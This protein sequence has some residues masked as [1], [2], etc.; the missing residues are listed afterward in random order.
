MGLKYKVNPRTTTKKMAIV[1]F[2]NV[3]NQFSI[4]TATILFII[5]ILFHCLVYS[6]PTISFTVKNNNSYSKQFISRIKESAKR[7]SRCV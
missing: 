7:C 3:I 4:D 6:Q 2:H 1:L 5:F